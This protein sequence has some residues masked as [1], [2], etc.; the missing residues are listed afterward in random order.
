MQ[1]RYREVISVQGSQTS[2]TDGLLIN[3]LG[4]KLDTD[5]KP[6]LFF[7]PTEKNAKS[8]SHRISKMIKSVPTLLDGLDQKRDNL[9]EKFISGVRFGMGWG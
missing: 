8:I 2:K 3:V 4:W 9:F 1:S 5:P 7:S 6:I